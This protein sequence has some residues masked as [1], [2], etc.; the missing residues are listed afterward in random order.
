LRPISSPSQTNSGCQCRLRELKSGHSSIR[1]FQLLITNY[2]LLYLALL[3]LLSSCTSP[4]LTPRPTPALVRVAVT[5]LTQPLLLDLAA[6]YATVNPDV[7]VAPSFTPEAALAAQLAA[8]QA[9]LALTT[10][11]PD[12]R[13]FATPLGYVP[14][15]FVVHPS[16]PL[17]ALTLPQAQ[18]LLA[19][20]LYDWSQV[21]GAPG[22]VQMVDRGPGT[23]AERALG[24]TALGPITVTTSALVAPT[25]A[26]MRQ[27][28]GQNPAAFGYLIGP[29]IDPSVKPLVL[30]DASGQPL[31]LRLLVVAQAPSN[32]AGAA[33]A[34]LAWAQS[35]A[36]QA[37]V[38]KRN[39]KLEAGSGK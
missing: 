23:A 15:Q 28:V 39:E 21:G 27:L 29:E 19:G 32:P 18:G 30:L 38:G 4:T 5:D 13:Q 6:A 24:A 8:G 20:R 31:P 11:A 1:R 3:I 7:V 9:D 2:Q 17:S 14:F 26:A 22:P 33:R 16:N 37:A 35:P 10:A 36:G 12:P 34:F 25:W